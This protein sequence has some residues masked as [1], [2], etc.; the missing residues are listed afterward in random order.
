MASGTITKGLQLKVVETI[1]SVPDRT[2]AAHDGFSVN[3][4]VDPQSNYTLLSHFLL[5]NSG[6]V[7]INSTIEDGQ[8]NKMNPQ[9]Y[10]VN[11]NN[12]SV[13]VNNNLKIILLSLFTKKGN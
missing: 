8:Y 10:V 12:S 11:T 3:L 13:T 6:I 2:I 4:T 5:S 9:V 7:G 1:Y